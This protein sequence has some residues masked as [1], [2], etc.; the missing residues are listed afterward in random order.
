[1]NKSDL[2]SAVIKAQRELGNKITNKQVASVVDL[3]FSIMAHEINEGSIVNI[4]NFGS[5]QKVMRP[6]RTGVNPNTREAIIVPA[7]EAAKFKASK[8]LID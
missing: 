6:E 7:K 2:T 3:T 8:N 4:S 5:F 1:M